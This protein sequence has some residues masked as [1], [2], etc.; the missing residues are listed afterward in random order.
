MINYQQSLYSP[1]FLTNSFF[2]YCQDALERSILFADVLRERGDIYLDHRKKGKPPV[3]E[4]EYEII[5]DGRSCERPVNYDLVRIIS[6]NEFDSSMKFVSSVRYMYHWNRRPIV[7]ID[8]RAGHGSGIGGM[9]RESEV[10]EAMR[11]GHPVYFIIFHPEPIPGQTLSDIAKAEAEFL[12]EVRRRHPDLK[13]PAVIGN[14]QAGWAAAMLVADQPD[15]ASILIANGAPFSYWAGVQGKN[16]MRFKGG[17]LGGSWSASLI[18]DLGNG[19]FDGAHLVDG[20]ESLNPAHT[21]WKK[22]YNVYMNIDSETRRFLTFEK[23]WSGFYFMNKEEIN[24]I[25]QGLFVGNELE[26]GKFI[27][28]EGE[29]PIDLKRIK[30]AVIFASKGDNIT[31]PQQALNWILEVYRDADHI[32]ELGNVIIYCVHETIGHLGI[33]TAV[34]VAEKEHRVIIGALRKID[35]LPAGLYELVINDNLEFTFQKRGFSDIRKYGDAR[36]DKAAFEK[37]KAKSEKNQRFYD[38]YVSPFVKAGTNS[39]VGESIKRMH[40]LRVTRYAF[41]RLNPASP[42]IEKMAEIVKENRHFVDEKNDFRKLEFYF[43]SIFEEFL[44]LFGNNRDAGQELAFGLLH[45]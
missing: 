18:S 16:P 8:P 9:K 14:C 43:A 22:M 20:F 35:N 34:K 12:K 11:M 29:A 26:Q 25:V 30:K 19:I 10:G 21:F 39:F 31:P 2:K 17:L 5:M 33:F 15:L 1:F 42:T 40:P 41:S 36:D 44:K 7:I 45:G 3:L 24:K 23:W 4:F 28:H 6:S 13:E 38:L 32:V 27:L 37:M